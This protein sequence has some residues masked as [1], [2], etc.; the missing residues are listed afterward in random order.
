[1]TMHFRS[2]AEFGM[3]L[4]EIQERP[5]LSI[6]FGQVTRAGL[7]CFSCVVRRR[8]TA[9]ERLLQATRPNKPVLCTFLLTLTPQF[10][11]LTPL[12]LPLQKF[13]QS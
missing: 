13:Y 10:T 11:L 5:P 6:D 7:L 2:L 1:M 3:I 9:A 8:K 4:Y 12:L